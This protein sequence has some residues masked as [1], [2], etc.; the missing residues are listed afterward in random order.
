MLVFLTF[1]FILSILVLVHEF[2]HY[3]AARKSGVAVEEFGVGI[4]PRIL[5]KKI[6]NT[7]YSINLLPFGGFVRLKGEDC[8]NPSSKVLADLS[9]FA[10]KS[11][12]QRFFI[13]IFGV[14]MNLVMGLL[15]YYLFFALNNFKS[16]S[17]P[18]L[19][20]YHFKFGQERILSTT[21][22]SVAPNSS[23]QK[24]GIEPGVA[25]LEI[26]G[27]AVYSIS[28][29]RKAVSAK[30][31]V[32]VKV[33]VMDLRTPS[34]TVYTISA[35]PQLSEEGYGVLGVYLSKSVIL[36]YDKGMQKVLAAPL[37]AYNMLSYSF[38]VLGN[39]VKISFQ[40][41]DIAPVSETLSGPV[42]IYTV[43]D[44][45][46]DYGG[47]KAYLGIIDLTALM[48]LSLAFLNIMPLPALDGGR[49]FFV[50]AER[51]RG[52]K[53]SPAFEGSVHKWG[54]LVLLG[55]LTLVTIKDIVRLF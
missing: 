55:I 54:M 36:S 51:F 15:L 44:R 17:L 16:L 40:E 38:S 35:V 12:K 48:S 39:L 41:K 8:L 14:T 42:G 4:P 45:I 3:I 9:N 24:S 52:K 18:L 50:L 49:L 11:P 19:F 22:F 28:D 32:P 20:D 26:D 7:L 43:V 23:A 1:I 6:G 25:I 5:G 34:H 13:L 29:V 30:V 27:Q 47:K 31:G 21:V 46:F 37:H 33:L 10:S 2:G 53:V